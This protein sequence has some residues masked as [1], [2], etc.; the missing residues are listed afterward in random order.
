MRRYLA[1]ALQFGREVARIGAAAVVALLI[2]GRFDALTARFTHR[3]G[4][5]RISSETRTRIAVGTKI[6]ITGA[7]FD[8]AQKPSLVV[9]TNDNCR[10]CMASRQFH[11]DVIATARARGMRVFVLAPD[12]RRQAAF[13]TAL[14]ALPDER[15]EWRDLSVSVLGTPTVAIA[16]SD[17]TVTKVW[18]GQLD[19]DQETTLR[20]EISQPAAVK[21]V[22]TPRLPSAQSAIVV[23]VRERDEYQAEHQKAAV[24]IPLGEVE[25]RARFELQTTREV[26]IDCSNLT[27]GKCQLARIVFNDAGFD[28]V[29]TLGEGK[30]VQSCRVSPQDGD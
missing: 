4:P 6:A 7:V 2:L 26:T 30:Y 8:N 22:A 12:M 20:Q 19:P 10:F 13:F 9:V 24:N 14:D 3:A 17:G 5:A 1:L 23:D 27:K 15:R 21:S 16:R 29:S 11:H 28:H 18:V 25:L